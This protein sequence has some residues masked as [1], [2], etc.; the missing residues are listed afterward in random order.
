MLLDAP[1]NTF[2]YFLLGFGIFAIVG[3]VFSAPSVWNKMFRPGEYELYLKRGEYGETDKKDGRRWSPF[4]EPLNAWTSL[5]Y[6]V[7]GFVVFCTGFHDSL[8]PKSM[9]VNNISLAWQF[10]LLY[11]ASTMYLGVASML[12][13]ASHAETWRK[14]DAGMTS[15]VVIAP[16]V[17]GLWDH[18]RPPAATAT[19]M[20]IAAILLQFSLTHGY[21]P[22]GSSDVLLPSLVVILYVIE[23]LPRYGG[24]VDEEQYTLWIQGL[25]AVV[26]SLLL[27]LADVKRNN[28]K[29]RSMF[30]NISL[31]LTLVAGGVLGISNYCVWVGL[32][33]WVMV[34]RNVS[35]GHVCW[36]IGSAYSL[37]SWWYMLR[38]RPGDSLAT[39][40]VVSDIPAATILFCIAL[41]NAVRRIFM[42]IPFSVEELR[43]RYMFVLEHAFFTVFC[44]YVIVVIPESDSQGSSWLFNSKNFWVS[45]VYS[46]GVFYIF[47]LAKVGTHLED[48]IM[49]ATKWYLHNKAVKA[50]TE[51][52][53]VPSE[54]D[55]KMVLHHIV[56][57]ALCIGSWWFDYARIG[58]CVMFLHDISD[59]PLDLSRLFSLLNWDMCVNVAVIFCVPMWFYW[60]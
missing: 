6:S 16:V 54:L 24:V 58:S 2:L 34:H 9:G 31:V 48:L 43:D 35:L 30:M 50:A 52:V 56:T 42:A 51:V 53:P 60:R 49:L 37:F 32:F 44:Y 36:H 27:R 45:P 10:S 39:D 4:E 33:A 3:A 18:L 20:V 17:F 21:L 59:I 40:G 41:K 29:A 26:L 22:Y 25:Y 8:M 13:H 1:P 12:F 15:G 28:D 47:Y 14:A 55:T 23:L 57:A 38:V 7:F 5:V 19:G 46:S 11:G